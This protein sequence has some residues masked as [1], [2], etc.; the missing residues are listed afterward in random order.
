MLGVIVLCLSMM[1]NPSQTAAAF[2]FYFLLT[3][4][5]TLGTAES[6]V[7]IGLLKLWSRT[8]AISAKCMNVPSSILVTGSS[9]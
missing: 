1:P 8:G 6:S 3:Q 5:P 2:V 4:D 7:G 9:H